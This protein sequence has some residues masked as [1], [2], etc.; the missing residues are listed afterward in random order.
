MVER[1]TCLFG[2]SYWQKLTVSQV[3]VRQ[4]REY[5]EW[6]RRRH[7]RQL[8]SGRT[9][10]STDGTRRRPAAA[11]CAARLRGC[12]ATFPR[13]RRSFPSAAAFDAAI[14]PRVARGPRGRCSTYLQLPPQPGAPLC[15][16]CLWHSGTAVAHLPGNG[17]CGPSKVADLVKATCVLHN[18]LRQ[19]GDGGRRCVGRRR[20]RAGH[21]GAHPTLQDITRAG[22]NTHSREAARVRQML[23]DYVTGAGSVPWQ[24]AAAG[25]E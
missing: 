15:R 9:S 18:L 21:G 16:E 19:R 12:A 6:E 2:N 4:R 17:G 22:T 8:R 25:L 14:R 11:E 20:T 7:L 5:G 1:K 24:R 3:L 13:R 10:P 23:A